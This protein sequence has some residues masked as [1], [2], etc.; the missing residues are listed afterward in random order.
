MPDK[1]YYQEIHLVNSILDL[2]QYM[3]GTVIF[4]FDYKTIIRQNE[5]P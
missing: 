5:I 1:I 4:R 3:I 2:K